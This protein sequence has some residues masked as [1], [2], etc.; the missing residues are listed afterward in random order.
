VAPAQA[1]VK[2][3]YVVSD[4]RTCD[5]TA[6]LL[7]PA[8]DKPDLKWVTFT[9]EQALQGMVQSGMPAPAAAAAVALGASLRSGALA[10]H[11]DTLAD[12]KLGKVKLEEY[13]RNEFV[14]AFRA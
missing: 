11:F 8:V 12:H 5:E 13:I 3:R 6:A 1:E 10:S 14:A 4:Q 9:D 7:G 2:V